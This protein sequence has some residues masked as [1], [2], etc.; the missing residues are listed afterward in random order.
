[1]ITT[2]SGA[3]LWRTEKYGLLVVE[4]EAMPIISELLRRLQ[5]AGVEVDLSPAEETQGGEGE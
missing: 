4:G 1:M 3:R 2:P 5:A